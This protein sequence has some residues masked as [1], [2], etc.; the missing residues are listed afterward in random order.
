MSAIYYRT[1]MK[2]DVNKYSEHVQGV[3]GLSNGTA[4]SSP[5]FI[6]ITSQ[7][8]ATNTSPREMCVSALAMRRC[9]ILLYRLILVKMIANNAATTCDWDTQNNNRPQ[10]SFKS[11]LASVIQKSI[12]GTGDWLCVYTLHLLFFK[13]T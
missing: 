13:K 4:G 9:R 8:S 11:S 1:A 2:A 3:F 7:N 10:I 5:K 12:C 6:L